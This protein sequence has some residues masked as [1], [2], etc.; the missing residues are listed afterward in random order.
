MLKYHINLCTGDDLC[1]PFFSNFSETP[2]MKVSFD[3]KISRWEITFSFIFQ[4]FAS[5]CGEQPFRACSHA[6]G[7][8]IAFEQLTDPGVNFA[9]EHGLTFVTLHM[10]LYLPQ[11]NFERWVTHCTT[12]GNW[13]CQ[14]NCSPCE[15]NVKVALRQE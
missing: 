4:E 7:K 8:L 13:P 12:P 1:S 3:V 6:L 15:K 2:C 10:N 14:D 11:G 9:S 5:I